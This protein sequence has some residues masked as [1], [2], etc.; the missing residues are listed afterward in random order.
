MKKSKRLRLD[1]LVLSKEGLLCAPRL[2]PGTAG[3]WERLLSIPRLPP[4]R[5]LRLTLMG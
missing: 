3:P 2:L 4:P 1:S 5:V